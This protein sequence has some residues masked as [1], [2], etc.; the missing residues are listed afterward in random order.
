MLV[1]YIGLIG[2]YLFLFGSIYLILRYTIFKMVWAEKIVFCKFY[3]N[4][5]ICVILSFLMV[6]FFFS[7]S[8]AG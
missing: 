6:F 2:T 7:V 4:E 1:N 5:L 8:T 3:L